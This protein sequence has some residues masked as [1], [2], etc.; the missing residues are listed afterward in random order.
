VSAITELHRQC[1][2]RWHRQA[3]A[4]DGY[5]GLLALVC[6]Q[7]C[8]NYLLWHEEDIARD[9]QASD[10]EIARVKRSID[11]LNQQ[12]ND[13]IEQLDDA[14]IAQLQAAGVSADP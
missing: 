4:D 1:V 6:R 11:V 12:R 3:V 5:E 7:H 2:V 8:A 14:L 10:A 9:P 13:R